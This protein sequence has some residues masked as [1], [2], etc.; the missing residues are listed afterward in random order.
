MEHPSRS[1]SQPLARRKFH[2]VTGSRD[3]GGLPAEAKAHIASESN[4][5]KRLREVQAFQVSVRRPSQEVSKSSEVSPKTRKVKGCAEGE[6]PRTVK[7]DSLPLTSTSGISPRSVIAH[8]VVGSTPRKRARVREATP[9]SPL[10]LVERNLIDMDPFETMPAKM[11]HSAK[12]LVGELGW[13]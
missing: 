7:S 3:G 13:I 6:G 1:P 11:N 12:Y 5:Q 10:G 2:F 4:R 9:P 8:A